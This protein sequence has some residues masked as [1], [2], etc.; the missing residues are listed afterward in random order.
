[1]M[2]SMKVGLALEE[3]L[4][5]LISHGIETENEEYIDIRV[6]KLDDQVMMRFR[7]L[8]AGIDPVMYYRENIGNREMAEELLGLKMIVKSA[9]HADFRQTLGASNLLLI[10]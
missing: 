2:Q 3:I 10:F 9:R 1:M 5:F 8:N 6:C 7:Y 4:T